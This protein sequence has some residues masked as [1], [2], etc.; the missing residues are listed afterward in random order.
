MGC[1]SP[2]YIKEERRGWPALMVRPKGGFLLLLGVGFPPF[3]VLIGG[4]RKGKRRGR[5]GGPVPFPIRIGLG[6]RAPTSWPPPLS[7]T[8]AH[9]GPLSPPGVLVT[10]RY[11]G[12]CPNLSETFPVCKHNLP[13]YQSSCLDHFETPRHVCD[14][15]RDSEQTSVIKSHNSLIQIVID[16]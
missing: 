2:P 3:L 15:I 10:L 4:G 13:I 9:V 7:P 1:P 16:H 11:S 14:H 6:G 8:K 12:I 5:K